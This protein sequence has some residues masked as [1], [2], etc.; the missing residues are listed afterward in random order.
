[1]KITRRRFIASAAA[2][3]LAVPQAISLAQ[4]GAG[5]SFETVKDKAADLAKRPFADDSPALPGPLRGL[6][7]N[8][9]RMIN[10][11]PERALWRDSGLFQVEL[12]H[13]GFAYDRKVTI[14]TVENGQVAEIA[15]SPD[16]FDYRQNDFRT[17]FGP[18]LGFSGFRLHFPL[19][20]GDYFDEFAVFQGASYYRLIGR[21]QQYGLS[22]RGL[23]INT[24][25]PQGE[26]FPFFKEFWL[27]R[28][29]ATTT[30]TVVYALLDSPSTTG[31]YKFVLLP[32]AETLARVELTLF[33]RADIKKLGVAPL[34][35]MFLHGKPGNRVFNDLRPEVHD[36]DG[37]LLHTGSG[38][39]LWRPVLDPRT[40]QVGRFADAGPKGFGLMQRERDFRAYE[41]LESNYQL[42]PSAWIEPDGDWGRGGVELVEIPSDEEINDN[43]VSYWVPDTPVKAAEAVSFAYHMR[44][45]TRDVTVPP[46]GRTW[47]TRVAPLKPV[48]AGKEDRKGP[49]RFWVDFNGG[50]IATLGAGLPIDAV[51]S[52]T[53]GKIDDVNSEKQGEGWRAV[54]TFTP[55]SG[56]DADL[57]G[58]LA[59]RGAPLTETWLYHWSGS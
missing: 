38:E 29:P 34:T 8:H 45:M 27:E 15:Y 16:L 3:S 28:P 42:R 51:F 13:R 17:D 59:L 30:W 5:F 1:M 4:Q 54:F 47:A 19:N 24:A 43:I 37:L 2:T 46:T 31:A 48:E 49:W 9:F 53:S 58:F 14:N 23:A 44:M 21:G 56:N 40:L 6:D 36:S 22:A 11:R 55:E 12:F 57:R 41:D 26:E 7:Y 35:S 18:D 39:W 20:R 50:D 33:P 32:D 52:T 25:G 10:F